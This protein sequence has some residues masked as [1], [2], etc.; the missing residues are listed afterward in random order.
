VPK[1]G[2][3]KGLVLWQEKDYNGAAKAFASAAESP[4]ATGWMVAA[5]SYWAGR[6]Q[7]RAGNHTKVRRWVKKAAEY[8]RTFYGVIASH[9]LGAEEDFNWRIEKFNSKHAD[10][11]NETKAGRRATLLIQ[12][13]RSDLAQEELFYLD[14]QEDEKLKA[15]LLAYADHYKLADLSM[16]LA[17]AVKP[18]NGGLYDAALY[19]DVAWKPYGGFKVD[20][21]L[22]NAVIRQESRFQVGAKNPSGATGIMQVMPQTAKYILAKTHGGFDEAFDYLHRP[23]V[24]MEFGQTYLHYLLNHPVVDGDLFSLAI[25]YNAGP[26]NLAKWKKEREHIDDPLMF[27]ETIPFNETRAFVDRVLSNY[28]IYRKRFGQDAP[29]LQSVAEGGWAH[30]APQDETGFALAMN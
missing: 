1:A 15:A 30:Y 20:K 24:N 3:V 26:G 14:V 27:V 7:M 28:W 17:N 6:A 29:S 5:A 22:I 12:A 21:A 25:A 11:I 16:R 19:P 10:L 23:E 2:W 13:G 9:A 8:P 4:Y 18:S